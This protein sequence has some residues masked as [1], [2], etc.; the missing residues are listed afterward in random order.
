[1]N[2]ATY[3]DALRVVQ[4]LTPEEQGRLIDALKAMNTRTDETVERREQGS[5]GAALGE[6]QPYTSPRSST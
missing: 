4:Q 2:F 5:T 3:E 6:T 1:M